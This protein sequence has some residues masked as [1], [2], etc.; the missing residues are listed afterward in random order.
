VRR[1][2]MGLVTDIKRDAVSCGLGNVV[3]NKVGRCRLTPG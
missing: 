1:E 3:G 2:L